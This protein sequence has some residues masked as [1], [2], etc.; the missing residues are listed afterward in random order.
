MV[1]T[2]FVLALA[3]TSCIAAGS[4]QAQ[5]A[6]PQ[7][8]EVTEFGGLV[9]N[10]PPNKIPPGSCVSGY[11]FDVSQA[12]SL[13][14]SL[15]SAEVSSA[16]GFGD[17]SNVTHLSDIDPGIQDSPRTLVLVGNLTSPTNG[18]AGNHVLSAAMTDAGTGPTVGTWHQVDDY[19]ELGLPNKVLCGVSSAAHANGMAYLAFPAL[20]GIL[21]V[22]GQGGSAGYSDPATCAWVGAPTRPTAA[23]TS[24]SGN[25]SGTYKYK[26]VYQSALGL[27]LASKPSNAV[28]T[29]SKKI[30]VSG[31][32]TGPSA[33]GGR[34]LYRT[35]GG[36]PTVSNT[37]FE[38]WVGN[39]CTG[40]AISGAGAT[41]TSAWDTSTT[42]LDIAAG[43][44]YDMRPNEYW[45]PRETRTQASY[46]GD[47]DHYWGRVLPKYVGDTRDSINASKLAESYTYPTGTKRSSCMEMIHRG[48][49]IACSGYEKFGVDVNI[50]AAYLSAVSC[51]NVDFDDLWDHT[52]DGLQLPSHA[53]Y[54]WTKTG[55]G[56]CSVSGGV[57]YMSDTSATPGTYFTK[58]HAS[59]PAK[60]LEMRFRQYM[61]VDWSG[62][63]FQKIVEAGGVSY[64]ENSLYVCIVGAGGA[65]H[66]YARPVK[67]W[68]R[69]RRIKIV[70]SGTSWS[71]YSDIED[72]NGWTL[73][74][75]GTDGAATSTA[76]VLG[77]WTTAGCDLYVDYL[78]Y[79][80][81]E[82]AGSSN[83][84]ASSAE[85]GHVTTGF[86]AGWQTLTWTKTAS[87]TAFD[88]M[89][90][91]VDEAQNTAGNYYWDKLYGINDYAYAGTYAAR[92]TRSG[93]NCYLGQ[94]WD[95]TSQRGAVVT[96]S[97][98]V[99]CATAGVACLRIWDDGAAAGTDSSY[100]SG[101]GDWELL[102]VSRTMGGSAGA[103]CRF[104]CRVMGTDTSA[105][106][107]VAEMYCGTQSDSYY[108]LTT[109]AD[110]T[111]TTYLDD[112]A[113]SSLG[114]QL[115]AATMNGY[116][117]ACEWIAWHNDRL[118]S[119]G[120]SPLTTQRQLL[121]YSDIGNGEHWPVLNWIAVNDT[122]GDV[123][124][125]LASFQGSLFVF[126]RTSI[127]RLRGTASDDFELR[128]AVA[129]VGCRD[130]RTIAVSDEAI[131]FYGSDGSWYAFNGTSLQDVGAQLRE[132]IADDVYLDNSSS[133]Y[134][135]SACFDGADYWCAYRKSAVQS[136]SD[137]L[138]RLGRGFWTRTR[139]DVQPSVVWKGRSRSSWLLGASWDGRVV[140]LEVPR[141]NGNSAGMRWVGPP[142]GLGDYLVDKKIERVVLTVE[143]S[144]A[145]TGTTAYTI[146]LHRNL[147]VDQLAVDEIPN[148]YSSKS[149]GLSTGVQELRWDLGAD[150]ADD[151]PPKSQMFRT[152][153]V[154]IQESGLATMA[155]E[156]YLP[157]PRILGL[158]IE[159]RP[160]R[161]LP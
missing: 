38:T 137:Y 79:D 148:V 13:R 82:Q 37:G 23:G 6:P 17:I 41:V 139:L 3:I 77:N 20:H 19:E 16:T 142:L 64:W 50:P 98:Y 140:R 51:V 144:W 5:P 138:L 122:D 84:S 116:V 132:H 72:G 159:Y 45:L 125:G 133:D 124:T 46:C 100:H 25:P 81:A 123:A 40:W 59:M 44:A 29:S 63:S 126:K 54:G 68:I 14:R 35:R 149:F 130:G 135:A 108:Y 65:P 55:S 10:Y 156:R 28:T 146:G 102:T 33:C 67:E 60:T 134:Q 158:M 150:F 47:A 155:A 66:Y 114:A 57:L 97:A 110:N 80:A 87:Q 15:G 109:I 76:T 92:V 43:H 7:F 160:N 128:L 31:I 69:W 93:A 48:S 71:L 34:L 117:P 73:L 96:F 8:Y 74:G 143:S 78:R 32:A 52:Y 127:W 90:V 18:A 75:S 129:G 24:T 42:L 12:G 39:T 121:W 11:N 22:G 58:V 118:W 111:T 94:T 36:N 141:M 136:T 49:T 113:D 88:S 53:D 70:R 103:A 85:K 1:R 61:T 95:G 105:Y 157:P 120:Q 27:S 62:G 91:S 89:W 145:T 147:T 2:S 115:D 99:K 83:Y 153:A 151:V 101:S 26:V 161:R 154:D 21:E 86:V 131:F 4:L 9:Q 119:I 106:F 104:D 112:I 107:D 152:I 30:Q 56:A